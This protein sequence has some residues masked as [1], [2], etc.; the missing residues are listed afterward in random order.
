MTFRAWLAALLAI[1]LA[2]LVVFFSRPIAEFFV[3]G[4]FPPPKAK[5]ALPI[6]TRVLSV[7]GTA[8]RLPRGATAP[9]SIKEGA[10]IHQYDQLQLLADSE[11]TLQ[12]E[13]GW[14]LKVGPHSVLTFELYSSDKTPAPA[15]LS[16]TKGA[17][18]VVNQGPL[19]QLFIMKDGLVFSPEAPPAPTPRQE[20]ELSL[21]E[22]RPPQK[23]QTDGPESFDSPAAAAPTP[24]TTPR[25][26]D[27][28]KLKNGQETLS[29]EYI[30]RSLQ[31]QS[32]AFRRCQQ[33]SVRDNTNSEGDLQ[34]SFTVH[35]DGRIQNVKAV[36]DRI[37]N[38][39]LVSCVTSVI[40][41]MRLKSFRGTP[42]TMTHP[43]Q[44]N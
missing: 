16:F 12:F 42:I 30:A 2:A 41:R 24:V 15:L 31:S 32:E 1:L 8:T 39:R 25:T 13:S 21:A 40:E 9:T 27:T 43:L 26:D 34:L 29:N 7:S 44:F 11:V 33:N 22:S 3:G 6:L 19:G 14:S 38:P 5:T 36:Q 10:E 18:T 35:P 28:I 37:Q 4:F 20:L 23:A 17:Y